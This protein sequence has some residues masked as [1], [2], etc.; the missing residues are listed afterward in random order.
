MG[1]SLTL[2]RVSNIDVRVHWSF[3]IILVYGA[4]VF[5]SP[6]V[7]PVGGALYGILVTL[8][9]FVCVTLHEFGHALV[10]QYFKIRV[11]SITL[12]PIG[13]VATLERAPDRPLHE[14]IIA[15][16]GP[17]VNI[18]IVAL[19]IPAVL[20]LSGPS[21]L[22]TGT[23]TPLYAIMR[24]VRTPGTANL[25]VYLILTN[26]MLA[27]FNLLPAFPLDGGRVLRALLAMVMPEL[28]ATQ[29][30][31]YV[32]RFMA[33]LL[34]LASVRLGIFMLLIAFFIYAGGGAELEALRSRLAL[35]RIPARRV[36]NP[37]QI[38]LYI[39]EPIERAVSLARYGGQSDFP[40]LDLAGRFVGA[41]VRAD[42]VSALQKDEHEYA[43]CGRHAWGRSDSRVS[44]RYTLHGHLGSVD[45]TAEPCGGRNGGALSSRS[46]FVG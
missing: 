7:G 29:V 6:G 41:L 37:N 46:Y 35:K 17:L 20:L 45:Q 40:V 10:A 9:L 21:L 31:V 24:N 19:L 26:V 27:V 23:L 4:F 2:F 30:A 22:D 3:L 13:G 36:L 18:A 8:L 42:L 14:L 16:A 5:N 39:S 1:R 38:N 12:L 11:P 43:G 34:A 15:L 32:G 44:A 28:R 25:L 33:A